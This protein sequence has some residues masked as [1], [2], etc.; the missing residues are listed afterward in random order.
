MKT[1][2]INRDHGV[3]AQARV[4]KRVVG[5]VALVLCVVSFIGRGVFA[6]APYPTYNANP[7]SANERP[8]FWLV[9]E[10]GAWRAPLPNWTLEEIM[11]VVDSKNEPTSA[12]PYSIQ[13]VTA[14]GVVEDGVARIGVTFVVNRRLRSRPSRTARRRRRLLRRRRPASPLLI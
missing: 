5:V 14:R 8:T 12:A 2:R 6:D 10:N 13:E 7:P 1:S 4:V 11:R 3:E 9:D